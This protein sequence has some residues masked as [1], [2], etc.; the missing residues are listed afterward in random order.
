MI[1]ALFVLCLS[2]WLFYEGRKRGSS[3]LEIAALIIITIQLA[4]WPFFLSTN[5]SYAFLGLTG[6][7]WAFYRFLKT[8]NQDV[9]TLSILVLLLGLVF[10]S[11]GLSP[12][13]FT[14]K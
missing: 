4:K 10:L 14:S 6:A 12:T 3:R 9:L 2:I 5:L 13:L 11:Q 1:T 7:A 8:K